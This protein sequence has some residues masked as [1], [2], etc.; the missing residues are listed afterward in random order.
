M[1]VRRHLET[2]RLVFDV[3][4]LIDGDTR[5]EQLLAAGTPAHF[6]E[7]MLRHWPLR[8]AAQRLIPEL[9]SNNALMFT[10]TQERK[11]GTLLDFICT[12]KER[13]PD[14][15]ILVRVGDFYEVFGLDALLVVQHCGLNAMGGKARAGCPIKNVQQTLD[16]LTA[17]G[18]SVAVFEEVDAPSAHRAATG[19]RGGIKQRF[20]SQVVTPGAATY[21]YQSALRREDIEYRDSRL[22]LGILISAGGAT[23]SS[24]IDDTRGGQ[25]GDGSFSYTVYEVSVDS[26]FVRV[27]ERLTE[28]AALCLIDASGATAGDGSVFYARVGGASPPK[29]TRRMLLST[30]VEG[31]T[32][33]RGAESNADAFLPEMLQHLSEDLQAPDIGKLDSFRFIDGHQQ[34]EDGRVQP[35]PLYSPTA[36]QLGLL[37]SPQVP[38]LV[39]HLLPKHDNP[40]SARSF[41]RRWVLRP[42]PPLVADQMQRLIR[43]LRQLPMGLPRLRTSLTTGKLVALCT[44]KQANASMFRDLAQCLEATRS[45]LE[46]DKSWQSA[47]ENFLD[48]LLALVEFESGIPVEQQRL[49]AECVQILDVIGRTVAGPAAAEDFFASMSL[50]PALQVAEEAVISMM[51]RNETDF[52]AAVQSSASSAT[53]KS[54]AAVD[55]ARSDLLTAVAEDL[56]HT[57]PNPTSS[58]RY[59]QLNNKFLLLQ[60]PPAAR[61]A[62][63]TVGSNPPVHPRD[64]NGRPMQNRFTSARV[65]ELTAQ[66]VGCCEDARHSAKLEL[67]RLS[68]DLV[69]KTLLTS[70]V[71][72]LQSNEMLLACSLHAQ[73]AQRR[74]WALPVLEP[75]TAAGHVEAVALDEPRRVC[76]VLP[77]LKPY[78]IESGEAVA[79]DVHVEGQW[80]LTGPNM[81]GKS[82]LL[83]SITAAALLANC[84]LS[85][86]V[87][88][89]DVGLAVPRLDG[90][91]L[92]TNGADCPSE[93][94]SAFALEALD[95][96]IL[97]RDL[98]PR[99]LAAVDELGRG[100]APEE[101]AA[102]NGALLE[103]FDQRGCP[104]VFATHLQKNLSRLPLQLPNT[105][106]KQLVVESTSHGDEFSWTYGLDDG[107]CDDSLALATARA[108]G[109]S[110]TVL[111]RAAVL[112]QDSGESEDAAAIPDTQTRREAVREL[113]AETSC[114]V[115]VPLVDQLPSSVAAALCCTHP[116]ILQPSWSPPP[117]VASGIPCVYILSFAGESYY[118]GETESLADRL[119]SHRRRFQHL[120]DFECWVFEQPDRSAARAAETAVIGKFREWGLLIHNSGVH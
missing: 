73:E 82:T 58:F 41:L 111:A 16:G 87:E 43:G 93:G 30:W 49:M 32:R 9:S 59:D 100:T 46:M 109:V 31:S 74:G 35:R 89:D 50:D 104:C 103:E 115:I 34:C 102:I 97:L 3:K 51:S 54:F 78:W 4:T 66:Y 12:Q 26:R 70:A 19:A 13:H 94:M 101:G 114:P 69:D 110:E 5:F 86:P 68:S 98:S 76:L 105:T 47:D 44:S 61:A 33:L 119:E 107:M 1:D 15:I 6:V 45:V 20:L 120:Q 64:R 52:R 36:Q 10:T 8:D 2:L 79:N 57:I 25:Q 21:V 63:D 65:E 11:K 106:Y 91:F 108:H 96:R 18:L 23:S 14:K 40:P 48:A 118:I 84:G 24:S 7:H 53:K 29:R 55:A 42:P 88:H 80:I 28:D 85:V 75:V 116:I 72:A 17:A 117:R 67:Q 62:N 22:Y 71:S 37:P 56:I 39:A 83:R 81:S 38:D 90:Y 92:R 95:M 60:S 99:S 77:R 112:L 27:S 113:N